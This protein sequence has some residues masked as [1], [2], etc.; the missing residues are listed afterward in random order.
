M[1]RVWK[2]YACTAWLRKVCVY[3]FENYNHLME[4]KIT[5]SNK[6]MHEELYSEMSSEKII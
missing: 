1:G 2:N 4:E 6:R 3:I 5:Y